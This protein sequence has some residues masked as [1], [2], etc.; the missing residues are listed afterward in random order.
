MGDGNNNNGTS[1]ELDSLAQS[2]LSVVSDKTGYPTQMLEL[3]MD[4]EADLGI[5]SIKRVEIMGAMQ[6]Q[7]PDLPPVN[8]EELAQLRTLGEIVNYMKV[9]LEVTEKKS[10]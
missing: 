1:V 2:L 3:D 4:L 8:P 10:L 7:H 6:S 5:D 9:P